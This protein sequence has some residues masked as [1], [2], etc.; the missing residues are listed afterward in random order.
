VLPEEGKEMP[1]LKATIMRRTP[2]SKARSV[3]LN[4]LCGSRS[5]E[6]GCRSA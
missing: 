5:Q 4:L 6:Y 3:I 1:A 2:V